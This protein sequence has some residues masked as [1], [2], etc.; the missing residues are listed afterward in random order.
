M[1]TIKKVLAL[2]LAVTALFCLPVQASA[3]ESSPTID[4]SKTG[5]LSVYK[6]DLT[7]AEAD[8][9]WDTNAYVSTG[10]YDQSVIDKM[11]NY[12]VPGVEFTYLRVADIALH[13]E[14]DDSGSKIITL[15]G[16]ADN[17]STNTVLSAIGLS[18]SEAYS[19][20]NGVFYFT[21]DSINSALV[22]ALATNS[23]AVKTALESHI[24]SAGGTAMNVTDEYGHSSADGLELGLASYDE[25]LN[26][27]GDGTMAY[28]EIPSLGIYLPVAHGTD[29]ATLENAVGHVGSSLPVGGKGTHAVLSGHSGMASEKMFSD[30]DQ[31]KIGDIFFIHVL[32][33]TLAYAV[34]DI[35]TV[36]PED[37]S[38]LAIER[39]KDL[40][41]LITC[42]P[43]GVNTH[44]LLV[45]GSR[46]DYDAQ[47][48]VA[49]IESL[50]PEAAGSTWINEYIKGIVLGVII[51]ILAVIAYMVMRRG[52]N[53]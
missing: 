29:A 16:F 27:N 6:Y 15:Y 8:G 52:Q 38:Q 48:V 28:I 26:L 23:T 36:L 13:T 9:A 44:R 21:S 7:K 42:T 46:I 18:A 19:S 35:S 39:D 40:V 4:Y 1:K 2:I 11:A 17:E 20:E 24:K 51:L 12:A 33:E 41:T 5:S 47:T 22:A 3:Q 49:D 53:G 10:L 43:F 30:L 37:T 45:R 14:Q 32:N 25:L 31:L 34:D 50:E